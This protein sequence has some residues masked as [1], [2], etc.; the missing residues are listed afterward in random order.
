M[1]F[2]A[3]RHPSARAR[4]IVGV[5]T[6]LAVAATTT[7][8]WATA[9]HAGPATGAQAGGF[10]PLPPA[11]AVAKQFTGPQVSLPRNARRATHGLAVEGAGK[12]AFDPKRTSRLRVVG[13]TAANAADYPSVVGIQTLFYNTADQTWYV[14][15]C[16]GSVL[17]PTKIL[18][19]EHCNVDLPYG[20]TQVFAGRN[21][22]NST[23]DTNGFVAGVAAAWD[24]QGYNL[25][26][27]RQAAS[28]GQPIPPPVDD[29]AVLTLKQPLPA[30]YVP[31]T[32]AGQ[33][34]AD[35]AAG[36][37]ATLV[38]YGVTSSTSN[39]QG[40]L[41]VATAPIADDSTCAGAAQW[42]SQFDPNRML[43]AGSPGSVDTCFGDSGGPIFTGEAGS[44]V[45]VGITD[46]GS[47]DCNSKLGV[48]EALNYY[49]NVV[50]QQIALASPNNLDWTG[51]GHSDLFGRLRSTGELVTFS[52]AGLMTGSLP[53]FDIGFYTSTSN[54]NGY[55]KLFRVNNWS[56]DGR[57]SV[58]AVN[59]SGHLFNFRSD[60][61]GNFDGRALEIGNGWNAYTD[62][63]VTNNWTGNG[64]PNLMGRTA[65]G[66][67]VLYTSDG[68]GG[69]SN[70]RGTEIGT[71][72]NQFDTVLTP[73]SWLGDGRQSLIGRT[74]AGKLRLYV[75]D[76]HGSWINPKGVE[77][78][79]GWGQF[80][81]FMSPGDFNGDN[82][83]DLLGVVRSTGALR[84]YTTNG[85]GGWINGSG[86]QIDTGWNN[87]NA[88]F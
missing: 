7:T 65:A 19:A 33:G 84:L 85:K 62:I 87:F 5:F 22:I 28:S 39:D 55:S 69:W 42:G 1:L 50:K 56:G 2:E 77:I 68:K 43:C 88:V 13:G 10:R 4:R 51:D 20:S 57:E 9:A 24:H 53:A 59:S 66:K 38:G 47:D 37:T 17:S 45:Q 54:W 63:M 81:T 52:G 18:T 11:P 21:D 35:P 79:T 16:T 48:Y 78:G 31:V 72:W 61:Q 49:S 46:W 8:L 64:M 74:P 75:S 70:G 58:F 15:T 23:T 30:A 67:L 41:R 40:I 27:Q 82:L 12:L 32:L 29:V 25:Q 3:K 60:G 26:A 71:G 14:S 80:S 36:T 34:D 83:V 6:G 44:R 73:G 76:G 86:R